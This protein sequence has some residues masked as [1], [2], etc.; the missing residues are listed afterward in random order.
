MPFRMLLEHD[1]DRGGER[2]EVLDVVGDH[3]TSLGAGELK[4]GPVAAT[5]QIFAL[6]HGAHIRPAAAQ[7]RGDLR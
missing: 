4:D 3:R 7:L 1:R 6:G 2:P 5:D